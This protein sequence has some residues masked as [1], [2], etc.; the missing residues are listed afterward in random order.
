MLAQAS[1]ALTIS[2][3]QPQWSE[4]DPSAWWQSTCSAMVELKKN[5]R[6]DSNR[7]MQLAYRVRCMVLRYST[8]IITS[9]LGCTIS[10][11]RNH[12]PADN[13]SFELNQIFNIF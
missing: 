5:T 10:K 4:Q 3:P 2:R 9:P 7:L 12:L 1:S 8:T 11:L 6:N 13:K